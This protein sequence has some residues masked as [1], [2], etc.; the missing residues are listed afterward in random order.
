MGL[1]SNFLKI[2]II[3]TSALSASSLV[4]C[5]YIPDR[6][7]YI[8]KLQNTHPQTG[9]NFTLNPSS[10]YEDITKPYTVDKKLESKSISIYYQYLENLLLKPFDQDLFTKVKHSLQ[11]NE[12][13]II[14]QYEGFKQSYTSIDEN[15]KQVDLYA[16]TV[17]FLKN[18]SRRFVFNG[19]WNQMSL[20]LDSLQ[21]QASG[22]IEQ[23]FAIQPVITNELNIK[24]LHFYQSFISYIE[25]LQRLFDDD[26]YTVEE[27]ISN[28]Q[29]ND[30]WDVYE[31]DFKEFIDKGIDLLDI[32]NYLLLR[33]PDLIFGGQKSMNEFESLW[34][35]IFNLFTKQLSR[36]YFL[37]HIDYSVLDDWWANN[38][39]FIHEHIN[40]DLEY[41]P[42]SDLTM[43][44]WQTQANDLLNKFKLNHLI[45]FADYN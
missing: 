22:N 19:D 3:L 29:T 23:L 33:A 43:S 16:P 24:Q 1:K 39:D 15:N 36:L 13:R 21:K 41:E 20:S 42:V 30:E 31:Q 26:N 35:G 40:K 44:Q 34:Y 5:A 8:Q 9:N 37:F 17:D 25:D 32:N 6:G 11:D 12:P 28:A 2:S 27:T 10:N 38:K 45:R 18:Q 14:E 7:L 4:S